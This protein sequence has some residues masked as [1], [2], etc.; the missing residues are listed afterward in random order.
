[1]RIAILIDAGIRE[2]SSAV[3]IPAIRNLIERLSSSFELTVFSLCL[4]DNRVEEFRCG[5]ASV[6]FVS[7]RYDD[8]LIRRVAA[9]RNAFAAE[10]QNARFDLVHGIRGFPC[11]LAAVLIGR[12]YRVPSIVSVQG[13][14][15]AALPHIGYGNMRRQ[16]LRAITRWMCKQ[17]SAVTV[18]TMFQEAALRSFGIAPRQLHVIPYG[19][20]LSVFSHATEK[21]VPPPTNFLHV[22]NLNQVKDQPTLL[23]AFARISQCL[24]ARLRLVGEDQL[25]GRI[26]RLARELGVAERVEFIGFV[27][28][29]LLAEHFHWA[30]VLLHTSLYEGQGVV[31]AEAAASRTLICGT[32]VG[33][34]SDLGGTCTVAAPVGDHAG[35]ADRVC[36]V[37]NDPARVEQLRAH[38]LRWAKEHSV[39]WTA[40]RFA[41]LYRTLACGTE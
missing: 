12:G 19:A 8:N 22:A 13:G 26:Q 25:D 29:K 15:T 16:P 17:A 39:D 36:T 23:R 27:P 14:E 30:H 28:Y 4:P 38:A 18:L 40:E 24:D 41:S 11:G 1:M 35:L 37:L 5:N 31:I 9:F 34:I 21:P 10:H 33:L 20:D 2:P 7:A 32:H 6:K 3:F